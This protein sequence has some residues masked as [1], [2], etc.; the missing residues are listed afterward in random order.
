MP[1]TNMDISQD[2]YDLA[3]FFNTRTQVE[4]IKH[5]KFYIIGNIYLQCGT[6]SKK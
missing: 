3:L 4:P 2:L 1:F 6:S 5:V